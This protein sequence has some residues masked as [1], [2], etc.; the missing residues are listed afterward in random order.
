MSEL[1][2]AVPVIPERQLPPQSAT[3]TLPAVPDLPRWM[4]AAV[5]FPV[6]CEYES[7]HFSVAFLPFSPTVPE[8]EPFAAGAFTTCLGTS[9]RPFSAADLPSLEPAAARLTTP[10]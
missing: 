3:S 9:R 5:A 6:R 4:C 7:F 10:R 2:V 8:K 1:N